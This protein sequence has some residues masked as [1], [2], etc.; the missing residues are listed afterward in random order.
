MSTDGVVVTW[1]NPSLLPMEIQIINRSHLVFW[2]L[3]ELKSLSLGIS[4]SCTCAIGTIRRGYAVQSPSQKERKENPLRLLFLCGKKKEWR[5]TEK[6]PQGSHSTIR[7]KKKTCRCELRAVHTRVACVTCN[8]PLFVPIPCRH[9][10]KTTL[11]IKDD[12]FILTTTVRE[13]FFWFFKK[14]WRPRVLADCSPK[15]PPLFWRSV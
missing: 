6:C 4:S 1:P 2:Q 7:E 5:E 12:G 9:S 3:K 11:S 10:T 14:R 8:P 15:P 13:I